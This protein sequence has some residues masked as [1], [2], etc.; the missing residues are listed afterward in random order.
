MRFTALKLAGAFL[1]DIDRHEDDRGF[2]ARSWCATEFT[3]RDLSVDIR[4]CSISFNARKGTLR[5][6]H[7]QS[8]PHQETKVVRCTAGAIYD[9]LVDVRSESPTY[10]EWLA[11]ELT[12]ENRHQLYIPPGIAHGF[13]TLCDA[14]EVFYQIS[15]DFVSSSSQG[16]RW[17]DPAIGVRWPEPVPTT[18][19]E[20]DRTFPDFAINSFDGRGRTD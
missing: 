18:I 8:A 5:G 13:Q 16:I 11:L 10:R 15:N 9:V 6:I 3:E 7:F 4:Q 1:V 19:S 14:S 12:A 2:F 17:N 20:R